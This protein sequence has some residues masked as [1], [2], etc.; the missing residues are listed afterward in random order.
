MPIWGKPGPGRD[1]IAHPAETRLRVF[2]SSATRAD[3]AGDQAFRVN[4]CNICC[5][6][7]TLILAK[8]PRSDA[9]GIKETAAWEFV[10]L[11]VTD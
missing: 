4:L 11:V 8:R 9:V 3:T 10:F 5:R 6:Y 7:Y 2:L 1:G